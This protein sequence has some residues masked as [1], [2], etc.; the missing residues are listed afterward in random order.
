MVSFLAVPETSMAAGH[1]FWAASLVDRDLVHFGGQDRPLVLVEAAL[2]AAVQAA[3]FLGAPEGFVSA[4][5]AGGS[6]PPARAAAETAKSKPP[7]RRRPGSGGAAARAPSLGARVTAMETALTDI[8]ALLLAGQPGAAGPAPLPPPLA[9]PP[10]AQPPGPP[11]KARVPL[12]TPAPA[13]LGPPAGPPPPAWLG[14]A[15][16]AGGIGSRVPVGPPPSMARARVLGG[17]PPPG[18]F[19]TGAAAASSGPAPPAALAPTLSWRS[20]RPP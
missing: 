9:P 14:G 1:V 5:E 8:R 17:P 4:E 15:L 7:P 20:R 18:G 10:A 19:G 11:P 6:T 13:P 3:G 16:P 12:V 2:V